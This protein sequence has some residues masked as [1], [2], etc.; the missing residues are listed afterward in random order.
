MSQ[1]RKIDYGSIFSISSPHTRRALHVRPV[2]DAVWE[3]YHLFLEPLIRGWVRNRSPLKFERSTGSVAMDLITTEAVKPRLLSMRVFACLRE[4]GFSGWSTFPVS[5]AGV[6][7]AEVP[8]YA[9]LAVTGRCGPIYPSKS[10]RGFKPERPDWEVMVGMYFNPRSWDGSS[11]F[12]SGG[13]LV[14]VVK[15]VKEALEEIEVT[16]MRFTALDQMENQ[17]AT[18]RMRRAKKLGS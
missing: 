9:G 8:G 3:K 15:E 11:I 4:H 13:G 7:G 16:N 12:T 5:V 10:V 18:L 17:L 6:G 14:F 2:H 1:S